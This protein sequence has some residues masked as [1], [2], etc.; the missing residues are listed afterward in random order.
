MKTASLTVN[1]GS[2]KDTVLALHSLA[3]MTMRPDF[4][5]CI[6]NGSSAEQISELRMGMP[7]DTVLIEL[8]ENMGVAAANIVGMDYAL[9]HDVEWTLFLNND[10]TVDPNCLSRCMAEA[11]ATERIAVVTPAVV[12]AD[13][14]D[15]LWFGGGYMS[16]W[17]G[18][19]RH[20]GL[21]QAAASPPATADTGYASFCCALVSSVAWRSVGPVR[22]DYFMYY[23]DAEWSQRVPDRGLEVSVLGRSSVQACRQCK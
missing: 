12:F 1:W 14:P 11:Q 16:D 18:F 5:I 15:Q 19:T 10:A 8:S 6:D 9:E 22:A 20:R 3:A 21:R 2:P 13:Q 17:F 23:E 4:I 7:R